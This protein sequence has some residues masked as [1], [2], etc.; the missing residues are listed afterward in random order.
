[1]EVSSVSNEDLVMAVEDLTVAVL[2]AAMT[3]EHARLG[4][5]YTWPLARDNVMAR[6]DQLDPHREF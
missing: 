1:M 6:F 3:I 5:E 4:D 2:V